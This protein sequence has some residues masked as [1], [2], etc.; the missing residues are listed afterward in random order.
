MFQNIAYGQ[1]GKVRNLP[2][3]IVLL[4]IW[5]V[6]PKCFTWKI[7]RQTRCYGI[8][9]S[10]KGVLHL[11]GRPAERT[12]LAMQQ[13]RQLE[14]RA[15]ECSLAPFNLLVGKQPL[16][17]RT[18]SHRTLISQVIHKQRLPFIL[19]LT[20]GSWELVWGINHVV[21]WNATAFGFCEVIGLQDQEAAKQ[22]PIRK[23]NAFQSLSLQTSQPAW[24]KTCRMQ[25]QVYKANVACKV[26]SLSIMFTILPLKIPA[27]FCLV[28]QNFG[29]S[30]N[31]WTIFPFSVLS[32]LP[33]CIPPWTLQSS[34]FSR[35]V[36]FFPVLS[37]SAITLIPL[38]VV[39]IPLI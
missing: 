28:M 23:P 32:L 21:I 39:C 20:Q 17:P 34:H 3:K 5:S 18:V 38:I 4:K 37:P 15:W 9:T 8:Q 24:T 31:L 1:L 13:H 26:K 14:S 2:D 35:S 11:Y 12:I 25:N 30:I 10:Q 19:Y 29:V 7:S 36:L 16:S 22:W 33:K 27:W 6:S